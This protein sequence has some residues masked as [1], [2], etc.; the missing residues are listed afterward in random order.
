[1]EQEEIIPVWHSI[2]L[3]IEYLI[4]VSV[5]INGYLKG[6]RKE[7]ELVTVTHSCQF[8]LWDGEISTALLIS[9]LWKLILSFAQ[10]EAKLHHHTLK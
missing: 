5:F 4:G 2:L 9:V 3:N 1:M 8:V 7:A 6:G 10:Q